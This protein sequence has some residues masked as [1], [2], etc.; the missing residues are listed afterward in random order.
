MPHPH[1]PIEKEWRLL[2]LEIAA[3]AA[4]GLDLS[5]WWRDDDADTDSAALQKLIEA[6]STHGV[7]LTLAVVPRR[8]KTSLARA[9][10][11]HPA[12]TPVSHGFAHINH[13]PPAAKQAE[14]GAHRPLAV[15]LSE[16]EEGIRIL[17]RLFAARLQPVLIPPWNRIAPELTPALPMIGFGGL[18][19]FQATLDRA[20]APGLVQTNCHIDFINWRNGKA[21]RPAQEILDDL[22]QHLM[23]RRICLTGRWSADKGGEILLHGKPVPLTFDPTEPTG[24]LTH[25]LAHSQLA[26][27]FLHKLFTR[28]SAP[29]GPVRWLSCTEAFSSLQAAAT[30]A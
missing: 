19:A 30:P 29:A 11:R 12:I 1:D 17:R 16:L 20:P 2:D 7:A 4:D 3:W 13:A 18:S 15:M 23:T 24:I 14:F 22:I 28:L 6:H 27:E 10:A 21:M 9:I 8:A 5:L 25:H 26:W